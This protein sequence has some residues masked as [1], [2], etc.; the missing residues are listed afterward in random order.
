MFQL[1]FYLDSPPAGG[2]FILAVC[3]V[4][5]FLRWVHPRNLW[6]LGDAL[7]WFFERRFHAVS[8]EKARRIGRH[9]L[10][11]MAIL[12]VVLGLFGI[13]VRSGIIVNGD[14]PQPMTLDES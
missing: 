10:L 9:F 8:P 6:R 2:L 4:F 3:A 13:L 7:S 5:L 1:P 12:F 11:A 14:R